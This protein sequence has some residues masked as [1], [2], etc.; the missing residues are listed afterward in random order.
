MQAPARRSL[1]SLAPLAGTVLLLA[2]ACASPDGH[3]DAKSPAHAKGGEASAPNV[4]FIMADDL[5]Y[6]EL[7]CYGQTKIKTPNLD[8][9]AS[10]GMRF[11]HHYTSAPVCAPG[12][13]SLMTGLHGG[14]AQVRD[15]FR[16]GTWES[17]KGQMPLREGTVTMAS[18]FKQRGY[19]TGAFGKWGLG[20]TGSSG[21]PLKRGFDR[22]YGYLCQRHAHN[23]Y[24]RYLVDDDKRVPLPGN[25]RGVKGKQ[26]AP[27]LIA[28]EL[29]SFIRA[30]HAKGKRFFAYYPTVIPHLALQ[31]PDEELDAYDFEET[32]YTGKSYQPH[33]RPKA[34]YAAMISYLDKE[35][36]RL[37]DMLDELGLTNDTLIIFTSDNGT[38]HIKQ[39]VDYDFFT[40][41]GKLRGLKGSVYEGGIRVPMIATWPGKI[42]AGSKSAHMSAHYDALATMAELLEL[43]APEGDGISYLPT[44]L[45]RPDQAEHEQLVWDFDGYG[46]QIA[47]R[48]GPY[49]LVKRRMRKK[50]DAPYELYLLTSDPSESRDISKDCP[51]VAADMYRRLIAER[52]RPETPEFVYGDYTR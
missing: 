24:P 18:L 7:G 20:N 28:R 26:Y 36:G 16:I 33:P 35:V 44:L 2:V 14:H 43:E 23:Y 11:S 6:R 10:R 9:L 22:F 37:L 1:A 15:N 51:D 45:G 17:H 31:V 3:G 13:C 48:R 32:P 40:S 30:Q 34:A 38:T 25:D 46:G 29:R 8:R 21:D 49:K 41:V 52:R 47:I 12:R 39:Q 42:A 5:G 27:T 19:A 4:V 50:P